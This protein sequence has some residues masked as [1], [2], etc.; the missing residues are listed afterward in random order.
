MRARLPLLTRLFA[1]GVCLG[2][3]ALVEAATYYVSKSGSDN[4]SCTTAQSP[5]GNTKRTIRAGLAC[6]SAGDTLV[7]HAG[8]YNE[9]NLNPPGGNS[10]SAPVTITVASGETAIVQPPGGTLYGFDTVSS[11]LIFQN[12]VIDGSLAPPDDLNLGNN[13]AIRLASYANETLPV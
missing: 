6:L 9:G 3:P 11:Y 4:N 1:A 2:L 10:W 13:A 12:L 5:N 7:A 8:T